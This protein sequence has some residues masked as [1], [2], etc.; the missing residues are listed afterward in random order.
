MVHW[1]RTVTHRTERRLL[2]HGVCKSSQSQ[3]SV[4]E[5]PR[6]SG[7]RKSRR[8][9]W[10]SQW[11]PVRVETRGKTLGGVPPSNGERTQRKLSLPLSWRREEL[12]Q[13]VDRRTLRRNY[14]V[15]FLWKSIQHRWVVVVPTTKQIRPKVWRWVVYRKC[16]TW[17]EDLHCKR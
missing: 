4:A 16:C 10:G 7:H 15:R 6:K 3:L 17:R 1:L 2:M 14:R 13:A 12:S 5:V 11:S 8:Q 9:K